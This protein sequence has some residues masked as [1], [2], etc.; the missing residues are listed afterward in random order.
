MTLPGYGDGPAWRRGPHRV[1]RRFAAA[2][3]DTLALPLAGLSAVDVGAGTG[4]MAEELAARGAAVLCADR[5]LPMVRQAPPPRLVCDVMALPLRDGCVD[6]AAAGF[7]LS[8]VGS[9]EAALRELARVTRPGG[10]VI[11]TAL[12]ARDPHPVKAV[13][14]GVLTQSGYRPPQWYLRLKHTG[15]VRVGEAGALARLAAGAGLSDVRVQECAA[16]LTGLD[17]DT[18]AAWRLGM[19]HVAPFVA[20]L[21]AAARDRLT[22]QVTEA[23]TEV[24]LAEPVRVLVL[25]GLADVNAHPAG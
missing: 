16:S 6:L 19:A 5:S 3:L 12:R 24:A 7:V 11:A 4:A 9:P 2:A 18:V 20:A 8:H 17:V 21:P 22:S 13:V 14:D 25:R 1:Y 10:P 15:E 23:I